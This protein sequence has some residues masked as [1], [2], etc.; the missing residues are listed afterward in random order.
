MQEPGMIE[1]LSK[2]ITRQGLTNTTLNY[3]RVRDFN[4]QWGWPGEHLMYSPL[5]L[6]LQFVLK[7]VLLDVFRELTCKKDLFIKIPTKHGSVLLLWMYEFLWILSLY[8][9]KVWIDFYHVSKVRLFVQCP[10][11]QLITFQNFNIQTCFSQFLWFFC[12]KCWFKEFT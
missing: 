6:Q 9:S 5:P 10:K 4:Q 12:L 7:W 8:Q 2:N 1:S 3:L 11:M